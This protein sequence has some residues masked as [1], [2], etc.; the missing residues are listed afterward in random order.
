MLTAAGMA[1][2][3]CHLDAL[4]CGDSR[5]SSAEK[6]A[7]DITGPHAGASKAGIRHTLGSPRPKV[8][9]EIGHPPDV[10]QGALARILNM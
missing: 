10:D 3:T 6:I 7:K 5:V 8:L 1:R 4:T 9:P 2:K